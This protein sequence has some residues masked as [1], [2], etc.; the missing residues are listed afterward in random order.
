VRRKDAFDVKRFRGVDGCEFGGFEDVEGAIACR[1][2]EVSHK[3][4]TRSW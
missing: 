3:Q 1:D 4:V 2:V